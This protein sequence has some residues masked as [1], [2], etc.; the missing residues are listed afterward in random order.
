MKQRLQ[1]ALNGLK[2]NPFDRYGLTQNSFPQIARAGYAEACRTL[3]SLGSEPIKDEAQIREVL[4][5]W[6]P[7]FIDLC[8]EKYIP[9]VYVEFDIEFEMPE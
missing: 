5:G 9:G 2:T 3:Q 4:K 6:D 7:A 8:C 1:V